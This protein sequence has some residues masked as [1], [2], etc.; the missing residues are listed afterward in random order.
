M[1]T[2]I[3]QCLDSNFLN[4]IFSEAGMNYLTIFEKFAIFYKSTYRRLLRFQHR[5]GGQ[6]HVVAEGQVVDGHRMDNQVPKGPCYLAVS[7]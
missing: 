3:S 1:Q 5:A 2:L 4:E 6:C 7:Q